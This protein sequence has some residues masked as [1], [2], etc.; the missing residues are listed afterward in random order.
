MKNTKKD[1]KIQKRYQNTKNKN[2]Y[3]IF[4]TKLGNKYKQ[5][6]K[7]IKTFLLEIKSQ[8]IRIMDPIIHDTKCP[9]ILNARYKTFANTIS[10]NQVDNNGKN[11]LI[12]ELHKLERK[13]KKVID[14][15]SDVTK[16]YFVD[17]K[18]EYD[19]GVES[20]TRTES[21]IAALQKH[22]ENKLKEHTISN[23]ESQLNDNEIDLDNLNKDYEMRKN[24]IHEKMLKHKGEYEMLQ[25]MYNNM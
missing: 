25:R 1:I 15:L 20:I 23:L 8:F 4:V 5:K 12:S 11:S 18:I 7:K 14:T 24:V 19:K 2:Y 21:N 13:H 22:L 17:Y 9:D 6:K 3:N 10:L 16:K